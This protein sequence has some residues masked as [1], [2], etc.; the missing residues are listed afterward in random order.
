MIK[1]KTNMVCESQRAGHP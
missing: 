1:L